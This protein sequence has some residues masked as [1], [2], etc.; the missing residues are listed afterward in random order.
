MNVPKLRAH[1]LRTEIWLVLISMLAGIVFA[2]RHSLLGSVGSGGCRGSI[3]STLHFVV[4]CRCFL[5]PIRGALVDALAHDSGQ[6]CEYACR[7]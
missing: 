4:F 3:H 7:L 6:R 1:K 5:C 2:A